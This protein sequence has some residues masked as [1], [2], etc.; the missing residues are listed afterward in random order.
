MKILKVILFILC[1]YFSS[2]QVFTQ[3]YVLSENAYISLLTAE[4]LPGND[5]ISMFGHSALRVKDADL[6]I[7]Y[8]FNYGLFDISISQ[9]VALIK[10]YLGKL[11]YE[12]WVSDFGDYYTT[13]VSEDRDLIEYVFNFSKEEK[14]QVLLQLMDKARKENRN[15]CFDFFDEN[16]TTFLR[17]LMLR[18]LNFNIEMPDSTTHHSYRDIAKAYTIDHPWVQFLIDLLAGSHLSDKAD[19]VR[20]LFIPHELE[21]A[22]KQSYIIDSDGV[23]RPLLREGCFLYTANLK[24][25]SP[26]LPVTPLVVGLIVLLVSIS[27]TVIE[28]VKKKHFKYID[29]VM[30]T[31]TGIVGVVLFIYTFIFNNWYAIDDFKLLWLNPIHLIAALLLLIA[32]RSRLLKFYH[33]LNI[34][35][36][37]IYLSGVFYI[38]QDYNIAFFP[39]VVSLLIRSVSCLIVDCLRCKGLSQNKCLPKKQQGFEVRD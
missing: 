32:P 20:G 30:L 34:V 15:Y 24:R 7:D 3:S 25:Q 29:V 21:K 5:I 26:P 2:M 1:F 37:S 19:P 8:V 16:C 31:I 13:I 10:L 4:P 33:I 23:K 17:D 6:D 35:L 36:L 38:H 27:L 11:E 12:M 22:W 14:E 39:L 28:L 18:D 9:P